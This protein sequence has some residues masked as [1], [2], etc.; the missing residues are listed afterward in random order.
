MT[1]LVAFIT[2][3]WLGLGSAIAGDMSLHAAYNHDQKTPM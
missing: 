2:G 1:L 3:L